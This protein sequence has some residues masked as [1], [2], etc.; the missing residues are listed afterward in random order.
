MASPGRKP[1]IETVRVPLVGNYSRRSD[2]GIPYTASGTVGIGVVGTAIVGGATGSSTG[3]DQRFVNCWP[4]KQVNPYTN[5]PRFYL[6]KRPGFEAHLTN[7]ANHVGQAVAVWS[8]KGSGTD[9]VSAFGNT[10]SEIFV[11]STSLGSITGKATGISETLL[12][13]TPYLAFVSTDSTGWYYPDAGALTKIA[14]VDFPGNAGRTLTGEFV[15]MDG[16]AF[17]MDTT[18]RIY[19]SDLNSITSWTSDNYTAAQMYPDLGI[20]LARYKNQLVAFGRETIEFFYNA[21]NETG[22]PLSRTPQTFVRMGCAGYKAIAQ[23]ED[24]VAWVS[25]SDKNGV[26]VYL[27]DNF[28]PKRISIPQI[29]AQIQLGSFDDI[30]VSGVR[31]LG[32]S[33]V[34]VTI[35]ATTFVYCIEDD[36]WHEWN[37]YSAY[38]LWH[39]L[40]GTSGNNSVVYSISARATG[41]KVYKIDSTDLQYQDD[42]NNYTMLAQTNKYDADMMRRKF[43]T[44]LTIVGDQTAS[45]TDLSISWTDDDYLTISSPR[46]VDLSDE[47][48]YLTNCGQF[49]RRAFFLSNTSNQFVRLEALEMQIKEGSH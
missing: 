25:A 23:F 44:R 22:S 4:Q 6:A 20:G 26:G 5:V 39:K 30:Y 46:T 1:E 41:G 42:G 29:D 16:Y 9:V 11:N 15:F 38:P 34:V 32:R 17:V 33:F 19:N 47:N 21:G 43:L 13:G 18:G 35:L 3:K 31:L 49:R 7:K 45:S 10:N 37:S 8:G 40:T 48:Q 36:S 27:M 12:S 14:D 28:Q 24:T 2:T